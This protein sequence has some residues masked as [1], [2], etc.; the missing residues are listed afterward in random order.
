[1]SIGRLGGDLP[2][3]RRFKC[4]AAPKERPLS[5]L[6]LGPVEEAGGRSLGPKVGAKQQTIQYTLNH[7]RTKP[8]SDQV[9]VNVD[10]AVYV[11]PCG[12]GYSCLGFDVCIDRAT[13]YARWLTDH[14]VAATAPDAM[15]RGTLDAYHAYRSLITQIG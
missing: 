9:T 1:M 15:R 2:A 13:K 3:N 7:E 4:A 10:Q 14:G 5:Q 11:I 6:R 12:N 8:I